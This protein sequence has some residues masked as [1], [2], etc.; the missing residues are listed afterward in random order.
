MTEWPPA[1]REC[2]TKSA[3]G[4]CADLHMKA[5]DFAV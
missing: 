5:P 1:L 2:R 4:S 3:L